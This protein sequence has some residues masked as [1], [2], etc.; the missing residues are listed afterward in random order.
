[1]KNL[2]TVLIN[3]YIKLIA[4]V[5]TLVC[6]GFK[7]ER[8]MANLS[9]GKS[10]TISSFEGFSQQKEVNKKRSSPKI[11]PDWIVFIDSKSVNAKRKNTSEIIGKWYGKWYNYERDFDRGTVD[12]IPPHPEKQKIILLIIGDKGLPRP[13]KKGKAFVWKGG[14]EFIFIRKFDR[15]QTH[16][17][18]KRQFGLTYFSFG[19][20]KAVSFEQVE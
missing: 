7:I 4:I 13:L 1:M 2:Y 15:T 17:Q 18:L 5:L 12:W 6:S 3:K 14:R 19:L 9:L 11:E 10:N 20:S 8:D 16:E